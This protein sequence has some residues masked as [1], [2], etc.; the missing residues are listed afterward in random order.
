M[1]RVDCKHAHRVLWYQGAYSCGIKGWFCE[2]KGEPCRKC[3][4]YERKEKTK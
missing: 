3:E 2:L 1:N 4:L